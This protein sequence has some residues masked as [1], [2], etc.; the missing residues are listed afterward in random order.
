MTKKKKFKLTNVGYTP[1]TAVFDK[2]ELS[3]YGIIAEPTEL[4]K[5]PG[6]PDHLSTT[7]E[8]TFQTKV[9]IEYNNLIY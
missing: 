9:C 3:K 7:F 6:H 4:Q 5:L 8:I 2:R 1:V